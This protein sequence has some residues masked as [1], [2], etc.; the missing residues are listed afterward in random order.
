[1]RPLARVFPA[2]NGVQH[3]DACA[4]GHEEVVHTGAPSDPRNLR[5]PLYCRAGTL[6]AGLRFHDVGLAWSGRRRVSG[7]EKV[8]QRV[9][10][11]EP[12]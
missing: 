1:M 4:A 9:V 3:P 7:Y 2:R 10:P 8:L 5:G 11:P 6:N 12:G